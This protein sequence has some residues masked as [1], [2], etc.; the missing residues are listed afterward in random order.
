MRVPWEAKL[1]TDPIVKVESQK[2]TQALAD[3]FKS[4]L[5]ACR[6]VQVQVRKIEVG[7]ETAGVENQVG[8][9]AVDP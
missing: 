9:S 5:K 6:S 1:A 8:P 7:L 4:R 3:C 2:K